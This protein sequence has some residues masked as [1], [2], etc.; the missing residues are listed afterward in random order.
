MSVGFRTGGSGLLTTGRWNDFELI[1]RPAGA[2]GPSTTTREDVS[3]T[4]RLF[5]IA[6]AGSRHAEEQQCENA[7]VKSCVAMVLRMA[8]QSLSRAQNYFG[9][10]YRRWKARLGGPKAVTAMAHKL[11]SVL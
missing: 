9:D 10:L 7:D 1:D 4:E 2:L 11:A 6:V 8:A 3:S 5:Y